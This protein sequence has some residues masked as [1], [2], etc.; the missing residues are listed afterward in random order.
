MVYLVQKENEQNQTQD[1]Y[2]KS[3][4]IHQLIITSL[5]EYRNY[6]ILLNISKY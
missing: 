5:F 6:N 4:Q 3:S 2:F 1:K